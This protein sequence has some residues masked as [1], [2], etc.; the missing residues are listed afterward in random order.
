MNKNTFEFLRTNHALGGRTFFM[1]EFVDYGRLLFLGM[2]GKIKRG[3][4]NVAGKK[5]D[6]KTL[7]SYWK[8]IFAVGR[9]WR[10]ELFDAIFQSKGRDLKI[11]QNHTFSND[12]K[13]VKFDS[14]LLDERT[15]MKD[16]TPGISLE[17]YLNSNH[18]S[19]GLPNKNVKSGDLYYWF[20][21]SENS[22]AR[23]DAGPNWAGLG[24]NWDPLGRF[25]G[26]GART[27]K[28]D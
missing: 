7:E 19:Q 22:A 17:D 6:K 24:C 18:T 20:S 25:P 28:Q 10:A 2:R 1:N 3:V 13:F 27:V 23:F 15:L 4:Y 14:N 12:G 5:L 21:E 8:D 11:Y 26:L 9:N 16:K